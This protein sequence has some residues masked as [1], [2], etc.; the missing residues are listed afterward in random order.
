MEKEL[1]LDYI[2]GLKAVAMVLVFNIHFLNAYYPG[3]YTLRPEDYHTA[4]QMEWW[5]GATPLNIIYAGKLGARIFLVI[6][7]FLTARKYFLNRKDRKGTG[8]EAG[9]LEKETLFSITVKKYLRLVFPILTVNVLI[10]LGMAI[11]LYCNDEAAALAGNEAFFGGYNTFLPNIFEA[12]KEAVFGCFIT[13]ANDYNG[14][15]WFIQMEF[16]GCILIG[17]LLVC[18]G[19]KKW[20]WLVYVLASLLLIRT[21]F[22]GM[23]LGL[24]IA[25][26][27]INEERLV[28][29][30]GSMQWLMWLGFVA[31]FYF[32]TFPSY[33]QNYEGSIYGIFPPKV[34]FYYNVAIPVLL[35]TISQLKPLQKMLSC[36]WLL[37][38]QKVSYC[39]YLIHFPL[40][41]TVSAGIYIWSHNVLNYHILAILNYILTFSAS[42][43]AGWILSITVDRFGMKIANKAYGA[44]LSKK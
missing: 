8:G 24:A 10:F 14:P 35:F 43:F 30:F 17:I 39:F 18:F 13:G 25:D 2:N 4:V 9:W 1:K 42:L 5:I 38:F 36:P 40:L 41:C 21:D 34:L 11:G 32:A 31:A 29:F 23:V 20:R 33:G 7:A 3:I 22:L 19:K 37:K 26:L 16:L 6:S 44:F 15:L 27:T 12:V 28:S